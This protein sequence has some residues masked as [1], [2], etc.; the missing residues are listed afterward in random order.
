MKDLK[1]TKRG[2]STCNPIQI[3]VPV[4]PYGMF[5][6][7]NLDKLLPVSASLSKVDRPKMYF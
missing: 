6:F 7:V 2:E 3:F 5:S 1:F 4:L